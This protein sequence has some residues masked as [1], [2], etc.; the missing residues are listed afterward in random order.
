MC[1][2][3]ALRTHARVFPPPPPPT[4]VGRWEGLVGRKEM[5]KYGKSRAGMR[6]SMQD[7]RIF[8]KVRQQASRLQLPRGRVQCRCLDCLSLSRYSKDSLA[9]RFKFY[10]LYMS[11]IILPFKSGRCR[12]VPE[13]CTTSPRSFPTLPRDAKCDAFRPPSQNLGS[14]MR[15]QSVELSMGK[16]YYC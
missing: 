7:T 14:W 2:C 3:V 6:H 9:L 8:E 5:G 10:I 13:V 1:G 12:Q 15:W 16:A 11:R 4:P